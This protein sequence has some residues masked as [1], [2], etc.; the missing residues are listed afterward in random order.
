[1]VM[2]VTEFGRTVHQNGS[3]GTDHGRASCV[4]AL[5]NTISG[6]N[7]YGEVSPLAI[8]NLEDGRDLP[9]TPDF[10]S[11]FAGV[12]TK[13]LGIKNTE[14]LFPNWSGEVMAI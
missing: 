3:L 9:V 2:A 4:F 7:V 6:G 8:E 14:V 5:G 10:R 1:M 12:A 13:H 11:L